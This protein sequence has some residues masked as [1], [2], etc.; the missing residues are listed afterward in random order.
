MTAVAVS[1]VLA[2]E[3]AAQPFQQDP[4]GPIKDVTADWQHYQPATAF[5]VKPD[6]NCVVA[7]ASRRIWGRA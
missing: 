4:M 3:A 6:A 5:C 1:S 2:D 7:L